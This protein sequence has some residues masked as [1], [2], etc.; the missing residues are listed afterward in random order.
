VTDEPAGGLTWGQLLRQ[1]EAALD[2]AGSSTS[3]SDALHI[4]TEAGPE[5]ANTM[6]HLDAAVTQRAVAHVDSMV[7]R[8][9]DGEPL[10]YV[11]SR[12]GF[13][14][15]DLAVDRRALIPRPETETVVEVALAEIDRVSPGRDPSV[16][17]L[18][19]GTGAIAL[20]VALERPA[21]NVWA[22]DASSD[23]LALAGANLAGLGR[24]ATRVQMLEGSWF[25]ALPDALRLDV[26]VIVSNPPYVT[27]AEVLPASVADWEPTIALR[28]GPDGLD[29]I[30]AI[31]A[32]APDWLRPGGA[33]VVEL[34]PGQS[35][36]VLDL[37]SARG[38]SDAE[39]TPDLTGRLRVFRAGWSG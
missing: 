13:R 5:G 15:L 14:H 34:A 9:A 3:R 28:S 35:E 7:T 8:R 12:W 1:A 17:D 19:T 38:Y 27:D 31:V 24:V 30:R 39:V 25:E 6:G 10:Q 21:A 32:G 23:A 29:A 20:S 37:A 4:I 16:V 33:L 22:T 2:A 18:G 36:A 11:V 26:D